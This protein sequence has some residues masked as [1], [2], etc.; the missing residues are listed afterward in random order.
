[1]HLSVRSVCSAVEK[2][3]ALYVFHMNV[4]SGRILSAHTMPFGPECFS[5]GAAL[6]YVFLPFQG[7]VHC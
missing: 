3:V 6:G 1:M 7:I 4:G 2:T 5:Q